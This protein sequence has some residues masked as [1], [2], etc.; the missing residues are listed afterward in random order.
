MIGLNKKDKGELSGRYVALVAI[1][2]V[3]FS[4]IIIRLGY[5][6]VIKSEYYKEKATTK[7][8]K[9]LSTIAPRG[10]I[11]DRNGEILA[12]NRQSFS[13]IFTE[14]TTSNEEFFRT[15]DKV[16]NLLEKNDEKL[17]DTFQLKVNPFRLEISSEAS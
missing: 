3:I 11:S 17:S 14:T 10:E 5:L 12:T 9:T 8:S 1:M 2:G 13:I 16:F 4:T 6:Q 15:I 7:N